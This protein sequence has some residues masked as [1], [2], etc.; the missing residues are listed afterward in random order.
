[1][2]HKA[3]KL[4]S[5]II[6]LFKSVLVAGVSRLEFIKDSREDG[7]RALYYLPMLSIK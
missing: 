1:M 3:L 2:V 7:I 5:V 6:D 4:V